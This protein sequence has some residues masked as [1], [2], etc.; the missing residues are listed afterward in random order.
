MDLRLLVFRASASDG[1]GDG[2]RVTARTVTTVS[3]STMLGALSVGTVAMDVSAKTPVH[4]YARSRHPYA[5]YIKT[6]S[7][8]AALHL[9]DKEAYLWEEER[10]W[11]CNKAESETRCQWKLP[12]AWSEI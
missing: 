7:Y 9:T 5:S 1:D 10:R 8:W 4:A 11:V 3:S 12:I 6:P 2:V